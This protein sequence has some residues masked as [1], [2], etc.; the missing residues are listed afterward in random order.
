MI[1]SDRSLR[2]QLA[3]GRIVIDPLDESLIQPSSIDVRIANLFRV[4][5]NH[6]AGVID[7]KLDLSELTELIEIPARRRV[8]AAPGRVRARLDVRADRASRRSRGA[9]RGQVESRPAGV[10]DPFDGGFHR[11]RVRRP[12]H[13]RA[14]ERGEPSDHALPGDED[15]PGELH[16]DDDAGRQPLRHRRH[17]VR[18][19]R[20]RRARRRA[21]TSRTSAEP[22][23]R[24]R[25]M[26]PG[27]TTA[28]SA[29]R[30]V[31]ARPL[32]SRRAGGSRCRRP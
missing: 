20:A 11:R 3:V 26:A 17:A 23:I 9:D 6:T 1:L 31:G 8:H 18:S 13:A 32:R 29:A 30:R 16:G 7:V 10:A 4:F 15:R 22:R 2:E 27:P 24:S 25:R 12:H 28:G 21:A 19:I 5:R 14:G